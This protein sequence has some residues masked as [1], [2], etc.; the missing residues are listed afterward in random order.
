MS[1]LKFDQLGKARRV[2]KMT[3]NSQLLST[4]FAMPMGIKF[5]SGPILF[6]YRNQ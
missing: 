1:R 6:E 2:P 3:K 4:V 5:R